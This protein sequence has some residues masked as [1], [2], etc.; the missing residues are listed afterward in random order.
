MVR[1]AE[2]ETFAEIAVADGVSAPMVRQRVSRLRRWFRARW[3]KELAALAVLALVACGAA[4]FTV[5][6]KTARDAAPHR[7]IG[8]D[9]TT[10][11]AR[12]T[13]PMPVETEP[14]PAT[15][16]PSEVRLPRNRP[17]VSPPAVGALDPKPTVRIVKHTTTSSSASGSPTTV[18]SF[19]VILPSVDL[20]S[21]VT[22]SSPKGVSHIAIAFRPDG[23]VESAHVDGGVVV[24]RT[25]ASCV[26]RL[27]SGLRTTPFVGETVVGGTYFS[28]VREAPPS[29]LRPY[30]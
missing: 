3:A 6:G 11:S 30:E 1:E 19:D 8:P 17:I 28:L 7:S 16:V 21:C 20:Q 24:G 27:F 9:P 14:K 10:P 5:R 2:G 18:T 22:A 25:E 13:E 23:S 4:L 26:E 15:W 12:P 29:W